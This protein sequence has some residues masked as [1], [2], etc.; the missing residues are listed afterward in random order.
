[1]TNHCVWLSVDPVCGK[2]DFYPKPIAKRI[3]KAFQERDMYVLNQIVLGKDFFN[4]T[5][6]FHTSG[7][8]YQT[9]PGMSMGRA[10][11][12]QPGY[13]SVKRININSTDEY[14]YIYSK[15]V[16]GEW[17]IC[18]S[19]LDSDIIFHEKIDK[20]CVIETTLLNIEDLKEWEPDH[21]NMENQSDLNNSI[22]VW[23]WCRGVPEKQGNLMLLDDNWWTPYLYPQNKIIE[24]AFKEQENDINITIP[25][26]DS[27]R[28]IHFNNDSCFGNQ[29]DD[30][31]NK[32]R[33]IRRKIVTVGQ[34]Q[35]LIKNINVI[36]RSI[37]D[38]LADLNDDSIPREFI[39]C[40]TQSI[41]NDPVKTVDGQ[42]YDRVAILKWFEQHSTSPLTGLVLPSKHLVS[43]F[44]LREQIQQYANSKHNVEVS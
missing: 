34:L 4:A 42:T 35:E 43:N 5:I 18:S 27:V 12:K 9:T 40:I 31:N 36:P 38:I 22:V 44:E 17:R 14:I 11:F 15:Q 16:H 28:R 29:Y 25:F 26:D 21:L 3:E 41:M 2:V 7:S 23:Q 20:N 30:V 10:G 39:C 33:L 1:M 37:S 32:S 6:H 13:R 24:K 19:Y 8:C